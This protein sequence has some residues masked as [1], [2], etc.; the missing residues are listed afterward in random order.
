MPIFWTSRV[1]R[2][3]ATAGRRMDR[4]DHPRACDVRH[5]DREQRA[6]YRKADLE[7]TALRQEPGQR[8]TR[9]TCQSAIRMDR[10]RCS[11]IAHHRPR[12]VGGRK[13]KADRTCRRVRAQ[14]PWRARCRSQT[15]ASGQ[16]TSLSPFPA[17]SSAV[18]AGGNY[19]V[20]VNERYAC[21]NH[22]RRG[23]CGNGRTIRR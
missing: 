15:P 10:Q 13:A 19:T 5:W 22:Y 16:P 6:V 18:P 9:V 11:R 3:G 7:Q 23:T 14:H 21:S 1:V 4:Y 17:C 8:Q 20:T 12:D 2:D